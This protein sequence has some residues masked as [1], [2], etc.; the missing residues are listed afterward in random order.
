MLYDLY[1]YYHVHVEVGVDVWLTVHENCVY[2]A[3]ECQKHESQAGPNFRGK[4]VFVAVCITVKS[5]HFL[6]SRNE[7]CRQIPHLL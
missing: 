6:R 1:H 3:G 5:T 2:L 4:N 7:C